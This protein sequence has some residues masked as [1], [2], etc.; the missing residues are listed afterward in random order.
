MDGKTICVIVTDLC[1]TYNAD[2]SVCTSCFKGYDLKDGSCI[3]SAS[4]NAKPSDL[5]CSSWD[6]DQQICL[7]CSKGF[8]FNPNKICVAVSDHCATYDIKS[9]ACTSCFKGYDLENGL[10]KFS[11]SNNAQPADLGC[12]LWSNE[13]QTCLECSK[14]F[15]FK[16]LHNGTIACAAVSDQCKTY[17]STGGDCTS[18]FKGYD[19]INGNCV[20]SSSN[21]AK[22]SDLGCS[23]WNWD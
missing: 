1:K 20:F 3:L 2:S 4:N 5:G 18:C 12:A 19:L 9:G 21:N 6:W 11:S 10:C 14:G 8:V 17:D 13:L 22:P 7:A 16:G 15:V 23:K